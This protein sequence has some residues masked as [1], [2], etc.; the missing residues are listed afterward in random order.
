LRRV[1]SNY[2][3]NKFEVGTG[4]ILHYD[5]KNEKLVPSKQ[6]D[7]IIYDNNRPVIFREGDFVILNDF[8]VRGIIEVK[9]KYYKNKFKSEFKTCTENAYFVAGENGLG[10]KGLFYFEFHPRNYKEAINFFNNL[11]SHWNNLIDVCLGTDIFVDRN[12]GKLSIEKREGLAYSYFIIQA[13]EKICGF[14]YRGRKMI[15][16]EKL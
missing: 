2:L 5:K 10:Y 8:L 1:L 11:P 15:D 4:F 7:I 9:T 13:L 16:L 6:I 3:P 12:D 14:D